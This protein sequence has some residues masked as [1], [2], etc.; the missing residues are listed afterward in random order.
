MHERE[1]RRRFDR[2]LR[3]FY[4]KE[5]LL[6]EYRVSERAL[7]HKLAEHLQKLFPR[8]D[9][10]CDYNKVGNGDPKRLDVLM[11][12]SPDCPHDCDRCQNNKCVIFPD[13]IVHRRGKEDNLLAIEAKTAWGRQSQVRDFTKLAKLTASEEYHYQ[14]GIAFRFA[15]TYAETLKTVIEYPR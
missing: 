12:G 13:I 4:A 9:V 6:I 8:H 7:T 11:W 15:E 14:L 5:A 1:I 10:D 2:A 3:S